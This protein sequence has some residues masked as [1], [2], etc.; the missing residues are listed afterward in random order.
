MPAIIAPPDIGEDFDPALLSEEALQSWWTDLSASQRRDIEKSFTMR[1]APNPGPQTDAYLSLADDMGYGGAAGCGKSFLFVLLGLTSHKNSIIFRFDGSQ[2]RQLVDDFV[3]AA[4]T[5]VGLNRQAGI[6]RV[7]TGHKDNGQPI[8]RTITFAGLGKP[9]QKEKYQGRA[10]DLQGFDEATEIGEDNVRFL[11]TWNRSPDRTQRVRRILTFNPPNDIKAMWILEHFGPWV[12]DQHPN[13]AK[14]GEIRYFYTNEEGQEIEALSPATIFLNLHGKRIPTT[15]ISRTFIPARL[16]DNP[17]QDERY[18][19]RLLALKPEERDRVYFGIINRRPKD[20]PDQVIPLRWIEEAEER[21]TPEGRSA[22]MDAIGVDVARGGDAHTV[23]SRRHAWWWDKLIRRQGKDTPDGHS[24]VAGYVEYRRDDADFCIDANGVGASPADIASKSYPCFP[25]TGQT[26]A[27]IPKI[28]RYLKMYNMRSALY[29]L[30]R[31]ILDPANNLL[32]ALPKDKRLRGQLAAPLY[33]IRADTLQ[34][35]PKEEVVELLG[36][37]PD[38]ADSVVVSLASTF[39]RRPLGIEN[40]VHQFRGS[41]KV[42][43][44]V[45]KQNAR[46]QRGG[47]HPAGWQYR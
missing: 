33:T 28:D 43:E 12:D 14:P 26:R 30:M 5:D 25:V 13:P 16:E 20:H 37:S 1:V 9:G 36:L 11:H 2:L 42:Q 22:P 18:A 46:F 34:V 21:W 15:P 4:G 8:I 19:D 32:P 24:V 38:D 35:Q 41:K 44:F 3:N 10:N 47:H 27:G 17:Y 7:V 6:F 29:W 31:N 23:Y 40:V 45:Q 39:K